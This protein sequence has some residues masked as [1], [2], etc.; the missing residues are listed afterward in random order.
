MAIYPL[1]AVRIRVLDIQKGN[2]PNGTEILF[3]WNMND[4]LDRYIGVKRMAIYFKCRPHQGT[5]HS[6]R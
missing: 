3:V 2:T 5:G 4:V 6:E 1:N